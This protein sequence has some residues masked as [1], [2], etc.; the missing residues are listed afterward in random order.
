MASRNEAKQQ[1]EKTSQTLIE[2]ALEL[3]AE[4]GY[5]SLSL[6]SVARKAGIAPTSFYRHFREIDEMG[7]AMVG[8]AKEALE[9]WLAGARKKMTFPAV[10]PGDAPDKLLTAIEHL[11]RPFVKTFTECFQNNPWLIHLF[12]QERTG[13]SVA[14][15]AAITEAVDGLIRDLSETL[16]KQGRSF[17]SR[18]G[19]LDMISETMITL[20]SRGV[21][22]YPSPPDAQPEYPTEPTIQKL[23]LL[24]LG[25]LILEQTKQE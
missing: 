8:Q 19:D 13:S 3:C 21:M 12:F 9:E 18:A 16:N 11:T 10:K 14:L 24:L 4:E 15:R 25:V 17:P 7:V 5:A 22:E 6:R 2:S 23:N 20:V 1:K